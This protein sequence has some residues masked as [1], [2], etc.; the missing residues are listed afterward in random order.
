MLRTAP[1]AT[2]ALASF[3][4]AQTDSNN[5]VGGTTYT[6]SGVTTPGGNMVVA[7]NASFG[8]T[9]MSGVTIGGNSMVERYAPL[10]GTNTLKFYDYTT[11]SGTADLVITVA[12]ASRISWASYDVGSRS[13]ITG[14]ADNTAS[15]SLDTSVNTTAGDT[16]I[17]WGWSQSSVTD[18]S[19]TGGLTGTGAAR[20]HLSLV[21]ST[22]YTS[23]FLQTNA[24]GGT[25]EA[26]GIDDAAAT[27]DMHHGAVVVY[28]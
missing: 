19:G 1:P 23:S 20:N 24:A 5:P 8:T 13:Y 4:E 22:I 3:I 21:E 6:F 11:T 18:H 2:T 28:R 7:V 16:V 25:P 15:A 9:T 27:N 14:A 12:S 26:F 10:V 17:G